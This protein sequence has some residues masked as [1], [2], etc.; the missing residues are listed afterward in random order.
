MPEKFDILKKLHPKVKWFCHLHSDMP[1]LA[2]EGIAID[3]IKR[4]AIAGIG[5]IANS[6]YSYNA[7]RVILT[8]A[9]VI[10]LPN[11]YLGK[12]RKK[13][14]ISSESSINIACLG[15]IRPMKNHLLQA[16]AAIKFS[17]EIEKR[18]YFYVNASRVEVG[19]EPV[20]KNLRALFSDPTG[21]ILI[22]KEW[23]TPEQM[24]DFCQK[25]DIGMQVSLT[26]TFNVVSADYVTAGLP[27]VVSKEVK[28]ASGF[29]K[30]DEDSVDDIVR[31]MKRVYRCKTLVRLNQLR[32]WMNSNAAQKMWVNFCR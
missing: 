17:R 27:I 25:M 32:L 28:W 22:E 14:S 7:L 12:M 15:A 3:W 18:L 21:P 6:K 24:L 20:L 5:L 1:F 29:C 26:E 10:Y 4:Y 23:M 19:G 31:I 8:E 30:A 16:M 9:Q 2:L 13:C 11:V